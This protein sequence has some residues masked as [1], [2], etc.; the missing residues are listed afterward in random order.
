MKSL[1]SPL[2]VLFLLLYCLAVAI[3]LAQSDRRLLV[4][5]LLNT[6]MVAV[7][8]LLTF[9]LTE[10]WAL[11]TAGVRRPWLGLVLWLLVVGLV[12]LYLFLNIR[13]L[14]WQILGLDVGDAVVGKLLLTVA[15]P[16]L[17]LWVKGDSLAGMGLNLRNCPQNLGLALLLACLLVGF[18]LPFRWGVIEQAG[19]QQVGLG[20]A[21][22]FTYNLFQT[23]F[24]EEFFFRAYLQGHLAVL[25]RSRFDAV[26]L[27][28]L[29]F[30]LLHI[31]WR[32]DMGFPMAFALSMLQ[33]TVRG[34]LYG[35]VWERT[36]SL[37]APTILH[38]TTNAILGLHHFVER[39]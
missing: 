38:A 3:L 33:E 30:G 24:P 12:S 27:A 32:L 20:F 9:R 39:V 11:P 17:L 34:L 22:G 37:I 19:W 7:G 29:I 23:G 36:R 15:L 31:L 5:G 35:V 25:F 13:W 28:S 21:L 26:L 1:I 14:H 2:G 18:L 16:L 10:G 6:V 4:M 8:I